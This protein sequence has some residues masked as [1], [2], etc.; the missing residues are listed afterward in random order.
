MEIN[1]VKS[2][3]EGNHEMFN[4]VFETYW[5][6]VYHYLLKRTKDVDCSMELTQNPGYH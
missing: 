3:K 2:L 1:R 5:E 6:K 4:L